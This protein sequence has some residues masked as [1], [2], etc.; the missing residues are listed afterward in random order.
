MATWSGIKKKLENDYLADSLKGR[1]SYF[2]TSYS[3]APDHI[4]RAA[5]KLDGVEILK[6]DYYK[7]QKL[8]WESYQELTAAAEE[9]QENS[10]IDSNA[11][12]KQSWLEA[13]EKGGFD[14]QIFYTA[15]EEYDNQSIEKSLES[16]NALVRILAVLDR[17]VGK[18]R[19]Q[20]LAGIWKN[21]PEWIRLFLN[22]RLDA[23][24]MR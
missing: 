16:N 22:L 19:L 17:R 14:N 20:D 18:R 23:E 7:L 6:S 1:I 24:N 21:E 8:Q 13:T 11:I 4:G 2:A 5:I 10:E 12:W 9:D 15:F 3:Y